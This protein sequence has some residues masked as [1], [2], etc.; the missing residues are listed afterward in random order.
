M[1]GQIKAKLK[2]KFIL[3]LTYGPSKYSLSGR[4]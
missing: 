3:D 4:R 2:G 1:T